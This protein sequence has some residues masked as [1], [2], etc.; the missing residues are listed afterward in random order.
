MKRC[1][2]CG[3]ET[4]DSEMNFCPHCSNNNGNGKVE[5]DMIHSSKASGNRTSKNTS[6]AI[7]GVSEIEQMKIVG[8]APNIQAEIGS[9]IID[10]DGNVVGRDIIDQRKFI[11]QR[12][13]YQKELSEA[14]R[15][16][17]NSSQYYNACVELIKDGFIDDD[18]KRQ[19]NALRHTLGLH[20]DIAEYIQKEVIEESAVKS[21]TMSCAVID[22]ITRVKGYIECNNKDQIQ[23]SFVQLEAYHKKI[24]NGHLDCLYF[25]LK[26]ILYPSYY[27]K[28]YSAGTK[29]YWEAFWSYVALARMDNEEAVQSLANLVRWDNYFPYQN[30]SILQTVGLLMQDKV[31]EAREAYKSIITGYSSDLEPVCDAIRELLDQD[32]DLVTDVSPQT[33]FYVESLFRRAYDQIKDQAGKRKAAEIAAIHQQELEAQAIQDKKENFILQYEAKKGSIRDALILSGATQTQYEEWKRYDANFRLSLENVDKRL[34]QEKIDAE[35]RIEELKEAFL[36]HYESDGGSIS[37]AMA[38]SGI[39]QSQFDEWKGTDS[40]FRTRLNDIDA[41]LAAKIEEENQKIQRQ[42]EHL[43]SCYEA[44]ECDLQKACKEVGSSPEIVKEWQNTDLSFN[45]S[46]NYIKRKYDAKRRK[47]ILAVVL[48]C[49]LIAIL[50]VIIGLQLKNAAN[51]RQLAA[52]ANDRYV[53]ATANL[54]AIIKGIPNNVDDISIEKHFNSLVAGSDTLKAIVILEQKPQLEG[55]EESKELRRGLLEKADVVYEYAKNLSGTSSSV[56]GYESERQIGLEYINKVENLK[57]IIS[58]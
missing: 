21:T 11:D 3:F 42:K 20:K 49:I 36:V 53:E 41:L 28:D 32:W 45:N 48:P 46:I 30:Q 16:R 24:D 51:A 7:T 4:A 22:F 33:K 39:E 23:A 1:P 50:C 9:K 12:S 40:R 19:L 26:A 6:N 38:H 15:L 17:Q 13:F 5:L 47:K 58:K 2:K 31:Q 37:V 43:L 25:Q 10:G 44:Y 56:P 27:L 57:H 29:S 52:A 8:G 54:S 14:E 55:K 35:R 18:A 34:A